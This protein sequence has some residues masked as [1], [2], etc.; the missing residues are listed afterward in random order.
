MNEINLLEV[1]KQQQEQIERLLDMFE[2]TLDNTD[3]ILTI[4]EHLTEGDQ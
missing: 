4:L 1:V 2:K 3:R